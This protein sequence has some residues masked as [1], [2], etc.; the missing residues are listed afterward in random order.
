MPFVHPPAI[1]GSF[2]ARE[3]AVLRLES[4][5][6]LELL[7]RNHNSSTAVDEAPCDH[8]GVDPLFVE[9]HGSKR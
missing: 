5:M 8:D 6:E 7:M 9:F 1:D 2:S 3:K 4:E